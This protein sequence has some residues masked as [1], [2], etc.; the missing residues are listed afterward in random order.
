VAST[1]PQADHQ[2]QLAGLAS[3]LA[4]QAGA[5]ILVDHATF[6]A[7]QMDDASRVSDTA[8]ST[9]TAGQR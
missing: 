9:R 4:Q 7:A 2:C 8:A 6:A 1:A 5:T 3:P